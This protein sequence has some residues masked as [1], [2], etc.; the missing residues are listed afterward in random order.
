MSKAILVIDM[1]ED[2][3]TC[4]FLSENEECYATGAIQT[5]SGDLLGRKPDWC[6]LRPMP[7]KKQL[8]GDM[9]NVQRMSEEISA[10]SWNACIDTITTVQKIN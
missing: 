7:E 10:A 5:L 6:P 2:C 3:A 8:S 4:K 1:P 9:H